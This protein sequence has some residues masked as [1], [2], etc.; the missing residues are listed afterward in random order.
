MATANFVLYLR[1]L[2]PAWPLAILTSA[3]AIYLYRYFLIGRQIAQKRR[4]VSLYRS[5]SLRVAGQN[6]QSGHTGEIFRTAAHLYD[7]DLAILGPDSLFGLLATVRTGV[8]QRGLANDLL[9]SPDR[10][11]TIER[12]QAI[13][14]LVPRN[15]L[16]E[17]I[18]LLGVTE[19]QQVPADFFDQWLDEPPPLFHP[20]YRIAL[21]ATTSTYLLL[22]LAGVLNLAPWS[23]LRLN[24]LAVLAIQS[25]IAL[26]IRKR[27]VPVLDAS[28]RLANQMEMFRD[29]LALLQ[30]EPFT[31]LRLV[32]LQ[33]RSR[34]P[35]NAVPLLA[36]MQRQF[37]V[38][39]QRTKNISLVLSLF[40]SVGTHAAISIAKWKRQNAAAMK[41]W[42]AA[43]AEF[44]SLNALA[45]YAYEHP[46]N[47][48][49][50]ILPTGTATFEATALAHPL[51]PHDAVTNDIALN[52]ITSLYLISGSNMAGKSTLLRAIGLNAVLAA[53]GAPIRATAARLSPLTIGASI[54]LT[55]SLAEGK[56]KF[57]AEVERLHAILQASAQ[58]RP[59][60]FLID[61]IFSGTNSL[62]RRIAA[63]A[64]ATA[65][66]RNNAIGALSTHDLTLTEMA[67]EPTLHAVNLHMASPDPA[68]P[69][70]FDYRLKPGVNPTS[71]ALAILRL[72][73]IDVES[74]RVAE[75]DPGTQTTSLEDPS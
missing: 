60:L 26:S 15:T 34:E 24:I 69:L 67:A 10:E 28:S 63:Q 9:H 72:I 47:I 62:D 11:A 42:L 64:V 36:Q 21:L 2:L 65:L 29:G 41:Q 4:L 54:A 3:I 55:D 33:R 18:H 12:Q 44:E 48:Y 68:D 56:S 35:S 43:W 19:F 58:P 6:P 8:G 53:A 66:L 25:A 71:N 30:A 17:Q 52:G 73:G 50:E 46:E 31:A 70:A 59:I 57:L 40:L 27:V 39:E 7:H 5:A 61:E 75:E 20:A 23:I 32:A 49:P 37:T 22:T 13:E 51:L 1:S 38:V 45:T 16:R 74:S 14:Q